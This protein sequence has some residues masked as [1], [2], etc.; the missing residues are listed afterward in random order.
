MTSFVPVS[1]TPAVHSIANIS[2]AIRNHIRRDSYGGFG[3]RSSANIAD[4]PLKNAHFESVSVAIVHLFQKKKLQE[5]ELSSLQ[6]SVRNLLKSEAGPLVYDFYKDKLVKKGMVI[7]REKI[8]LETGK[9]LLGNLGNQWDYFYC[10]ILPVIQSLLYPIKVSQSLL[11][12]IKTKSY[13]IREVTLLEFRNTVLLKL[14][15]ADALQSL[16]DDEKA[17][18]SV[19]QM[20]LVLQSVRDQTI[21]E[22]SMKLEKLVARVVSPYLGILGLYNGGTEPDIQS[23]FKIP[24]RLQQIPVIVTQGESDSD[25]ESTT[26]DVTSDQGNISPL[27]SGL[28]HRLSRKRTSGLLPHPLLSVVKEDRST[29]RR[30]SIA[31]S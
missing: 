29:I 20:L 12:P 3:R 1:G 16:P 8:K 27:I 15:V 9:S 7:L 5:S 23:N 4:L 13:S 22:N 11:Y 25:D 10:E 31:T 2:E 18:S 14:P 17:P 21:T 30:Y 28:S 19:Q 6:E 24:V 26:N